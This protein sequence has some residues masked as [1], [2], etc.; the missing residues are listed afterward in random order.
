MSKENADR[1]KDISTRL[2]KYM[3]QIKSGE[4]AVTEEH[5]DIVN[6]LENVVSKY[7]NIHNKGEKS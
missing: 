1:L 3:D 5:F 2:E 7:E 6:E 4:V